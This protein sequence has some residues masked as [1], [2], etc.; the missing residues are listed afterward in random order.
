MVD[1]VPYK[2]FGCRNQILQPNKF[3]GYAYLSQMS[4]EKFAAIRHIVGTMLT[5]IFGRHNVSF[6]WSKHF[7]WIT[8]PQTN[9]LT[10][11]I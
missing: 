4:S 10:K 2:L 8:Q 3:D 11:R 1:F 7:V 5:K 9:A 6:G